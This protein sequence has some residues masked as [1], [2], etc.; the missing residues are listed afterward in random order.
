MTIYELIKDQDDLAWIHLASCSLITLGPA[1]W[2]RTLTVP[3]I[4]LLLSLYIL[5]SGITFLLT[6]V[7]VKQSEQ[8]LIFCSAVSPLAVSRYSWPS[9]S[10]PLILSVC[11]ALWSH[12]LWYRMI[13][14]NLSYK[15]LILDFYF[16]LTSSFWHKRNLILN[17]WEL[18]N[19]SDVLYKKPVAQ[20]FIEYIFS[21]CTHGEDGGGRERSQ[22]KRGCYNSPDIR[23]Q[24]KR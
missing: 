14:S 9:W 3:Q 1:S 12:S 2:E 22:L 13:F 8:F 7:Y 10:R 23:F 24:D 6:W 4:S 16:C 18:N 20:W 5:Q 19:E 17:S 11:A 21:P 15:I